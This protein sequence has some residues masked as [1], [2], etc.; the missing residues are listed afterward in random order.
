MKTVTLQVGNELCP[1]KL[2][3][4]DTFTYRLWWATK[5]NKQMTVMCVSM[6]RLFTRHL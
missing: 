4:T 1:Q 2:N 6:S 5:L 3:Y